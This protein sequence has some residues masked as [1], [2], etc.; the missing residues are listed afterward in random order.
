MERTSG[1][2][3]VSLLLKAQSAL[4]SNLAA[5]SFILPHPK[6]CGKGDYTK[7]PGIPTHGFIVLIIKVSPFI[8]SESHRVQFIPVVSFLHY[9]QL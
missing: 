5:Q 6:T 9:V 4:R 8:Q 2:L 1:G 7:S 3:Y